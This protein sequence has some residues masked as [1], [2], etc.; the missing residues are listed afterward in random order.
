[1]RPILADLSTALRRLHKALINAE[2]ERFGPINGPFQFLDLV[3]RHAHF[4]WLHI[5]SELM[6][7]LDELVDG[8]EEVTRAQAGAFRTTI[9]GLIGPRT[10]TQPEFRKRYLELLQQSPAVTMAHGELR[11]VLAR[12]PNPSPDAPAGPLC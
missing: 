3:T 2:A 10:P 11:Q 7:E 1:M 6:V 12:L 4:A 5:L 9:E 8:D